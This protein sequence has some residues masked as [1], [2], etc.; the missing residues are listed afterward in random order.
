LIVVIEGPSAVGKTTW[1]R[2]QFPKDF[3][4]EA[5]ENAEAPDV[6]GD[7]SEVAS[8]W[9]NFNIGLWQTALQI[10]Q[11]RGIAICDGDPFH[12]YFSWSLWKSGAIPGTLFEMELPLYR[13]AIGDGRLGF[14]DLV[15]WREA[16]TEELRRRARSDTSRQRRRHEIYLSLVPWMKVWFEARE[17][18]F[19]GSVRAWP[20]DLH[21]E[22]L[23]GSVPLTHRYDVKMIDQM[24]ET[25]NSITG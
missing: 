6:N 11:Q 12:L 7:P 15:C 10:E 5:G 20:E 24:T 21:A 22:V 3:V 25:L 18:V 23:T 9:V 16:P 17:R 2:T 14:A 13:R 19:P 8:F 1:C 4:E